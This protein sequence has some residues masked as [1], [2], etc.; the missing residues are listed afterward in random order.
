[1]VAQGIIGDWREPEVLRFAPVPL[2]NSF[3][4]VYK[5]GQII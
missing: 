2:Y 1:L 3:E 4:E 5:F